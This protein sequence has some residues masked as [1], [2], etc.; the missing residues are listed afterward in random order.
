MSI[1][2]IVCAAV[3]VLSLSVAADAK[4]H[5]NALGLRF[6]GGSLSGAELNYQKGLRANRLELGASWG[7]ESHPQHL[8]YDNNG[9][10]HYSGKYNT[11]HI[12]V[13]GFY[14]WHFN[15]A[16]VNGL[17]WYVGP[18]A[19]VGFWSWHRE[20]AGTSYKEDDSGVDINAGGQIGIEYDLNAVKVP[21]LL[22]LDLR[23][24]LGLPGGGIWY[25]AG[26]GVRYTF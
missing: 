5:S 16:D 25:H 26:L 13:I 23:A 2:R 7:F 24:M 12:G 22:S 4:V 1:K 15:L 8:W 11:M 17:N 20:Y 14:Q 10:P 3:A 6:G 18:G 21:L 19:G 9:A